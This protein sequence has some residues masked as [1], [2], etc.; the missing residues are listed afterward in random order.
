[1]VF[2]NASLVLM[3]FSKPHFIFLF[4]MFFYL[5]LRNFPLLFNREGKQE[6][7]GER[8]TLMQERSTDCLPPICAPTGIKP[9]T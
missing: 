4:L 7:K 2:I 1:M 3:S 5:L 6:R 8:E 9:T